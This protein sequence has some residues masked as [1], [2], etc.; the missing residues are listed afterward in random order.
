LPKKDIIPS[1]LKYADHLAKLVEINQEKIG[2]LPEP[3]K[4]VL[5]KLSKLCKDIYD[6]TEYLEKTVASAR[7]ITDKKELSFCYK[8]NVIPAMETLRKSAD[9]AE[10]LLGTEYLPYP[11]YEDLL[12]GV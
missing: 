8:D 4:T 5:S 2:I 7:S 6:G 12:F 3:E 11:T 10:T 9:E 1:I